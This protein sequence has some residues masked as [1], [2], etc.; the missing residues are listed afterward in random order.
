MKKIGI[1]IIGLGAIGERLIDTFKKHPR[2]DIVGVYDVDPNRMNAISK[3]YGLTIVDHYDSLIENDD[4]EMIYIAVPPKYH[5]EIA[6]KAMKAKKHVLCE[7]PLANSIEEAEE[8]Y[9]IATEMDVVHGMNFPLYYSF[10]YKYIKRMLKEGQ[11]GDLRR[12]ELSALFPV[13]P[14]KWQQ[15][16]WIDTREQGGFTREIFTHFIQLIQASFGEINNIQSF[17]EYPK[18]SLKSES[19]LI[20]IGELNNDIKL[21]VSGITDVNQKEAIKLVI[22]GTKGSAEILNWRD[23]FRNT[24]EIGRTLVSPEPV[25]ATYDLIDSFYK[26]MDGVENNL[27]N[28]NDGY[29]VAKVIESLIQG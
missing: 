26:A 9:N 14:R 1:G 25:D 13:W 19:G 17:V 12:I 22:Y 7:K 16:N 11:L 3:K 29:N 6:I 10:A 4:I 18:D 24:S 8:M 27:V 20:A 15:N 2:T 21:V 23:L 28:F 5:H